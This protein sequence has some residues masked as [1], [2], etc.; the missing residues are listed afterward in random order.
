MYVWSE[1]KIK[2]TDMHDSNNQKKNSHSPLE[3]KTIEGNKT[4][5]LVS[6]STVIGA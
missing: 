4:T 2:M 1:V 5:L 3:E 6:P